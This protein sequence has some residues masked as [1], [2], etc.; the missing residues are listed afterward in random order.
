MRA[1][2]DT[3]ILVYAEGLNG[4][5]KALQARSLIARLGDR[6]VAPIQVLAEFYNVLT[7]KARLPREEARGV[8][9]ALSSFMTTIPT[10]GEILDHALEL[11]VRHDLRIFDAVIVCAAAQGGCPILLSEDM[12]DGFSYRGTTIVNPFARTP[13]P[14][15]AAFLEGLL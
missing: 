8:V 1:A 11:S 7:L 6:A 3:N 5:E 12:H 13:H 15:L 2:L 4:P 9:S 10:S 14:A